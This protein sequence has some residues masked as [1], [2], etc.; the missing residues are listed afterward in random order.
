MHFKYKYTNNLEIKRICHVNNNP[1]KAGVTVLI[2]DKIDFK[3]SS[4]TRNK[5][6]YFIMIKVSTHQEDITMTS[7]C[8]PNITELQ[9]YRKEM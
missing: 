5:E 6:G 9:K 1:K 8:T 2:L 7:L 3:T 4:I